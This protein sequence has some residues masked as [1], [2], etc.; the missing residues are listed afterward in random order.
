LDRDWRRHL[1]RLFLPPS[2]APH[3]PAPPL[4][5]RHLEGCQVLPSREVMIREYLPK[6]GVVAEV[7]V[8][9]GYNART[10]LEGAQPRELHLIDQNF[11]RFHEHGLFELT[12]DIHLHEGQSAPALASFPDAYFDWIYIDADHQYLG[13]ARDIQQAKRAVKPDGFLVFND[14]VFYS[15]T[16]LLRYGVVHAVNELCLAEDWRFR[17]FALEPQMHCDVALVRY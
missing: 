13:I 15:H 7:G 9:E 2:G 5:A 6:S 11:S 12:D 16:E 17:Y 8:S 4:E 10:I 14:Y 1:A 3:E